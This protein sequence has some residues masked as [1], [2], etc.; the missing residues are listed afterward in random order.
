[1]HIHACKLQP[2]AQVHDIVCAA[3]FLSSVRFF[4]IILMCYCGW[5]NDSMKVSDSFGIVCKCLVSCTLKYVYILVAIFDLHVSQCVFFSFNGIFSF[6]LSFEDACNCSVNHLPIDGATTI[7]FYLNCSTAHNWLNKEEKK[8]KMQ[9]IV[10]FFYWSFF[11]LM[12]IFLYLIFPNPICAFYLMWFF[13]HFFF[14]G[15]F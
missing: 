11:Y 5:P 12:K 8:M 13:S 2:Q 7:H 1:M 3:F 6:F 9:K 4:F 15:L 10:V 14:V